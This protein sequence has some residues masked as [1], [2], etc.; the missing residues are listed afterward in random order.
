MHDERAHLTVVIGGARSGKSRY[1][2][3]LAVSLDGFR[4]YIA[5]AEPFDEE[6]RQRIAWHR[7]NREG[8]FD[9]TIE[10]PLDLAGAIATIPGDTRIAVIDCVT[11]WL[12]NLMHH[13]GIR[14]TYDEI[15]AFMR[16]LKTRK[17][18][19]IIVSNEVGQ[20]IVPADALSRAFRDQ[21]GWLN[22]D[23]TRIADRVVW[24]VAGI[25]VT[26][27]GERALCEE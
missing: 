10:E 13:H 19:C 6:M 26:I 7:R 4:T 5:T 12:G 18:D 1:A 25:P 8:H 24:M 15:S 11:V 23:L 27:K 16:A 9:L 21:A 2:E 17:T 22:Q 14:D 20:G 3:Q